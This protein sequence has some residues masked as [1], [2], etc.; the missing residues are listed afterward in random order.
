MEQSERTKV[1]HQHWC[2]SA[3][4]KNREQAA[5]DAECER[6]GGAIRCSTETL[7]ARQVRR[8]KARPGEV[9]VTWSN[10]GMTWET[11]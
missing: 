5:P 1:V 7:T 9:K 10:G 6:Q 2:G 4:W 11:E 8:F 3:H